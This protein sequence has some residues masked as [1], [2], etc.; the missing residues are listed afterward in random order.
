LHFCYIYFH[1]FYMYN[2]YNYFEP[3]ALNA[4]FQHFIPRFNKTS[5]LCG[6]HSKRGYGGEKSPKDSVKTG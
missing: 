3:H 6:P 5:L 4:E 2:Y 1:C